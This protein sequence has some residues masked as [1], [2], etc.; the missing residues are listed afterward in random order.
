MRYT[1]YTW[2]LID[3]CVDHAET[4]AAVITRTDQLRGEFH[5]LRQM[6]ASRTEGLQTRA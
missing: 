6:L 3:T 2:Q 4:V 5:R 1:W